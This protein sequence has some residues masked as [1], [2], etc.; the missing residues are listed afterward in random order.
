MLENVKISI[1]RVCKMGTALAIAW[2][3]LAK[4]PVSSEDLVL[5]KLNRDE[6]L[7]FII[8]NGTNILS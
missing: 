5:Y 7:R 2:A 4:K 3:N 8:L 1:E 6:F